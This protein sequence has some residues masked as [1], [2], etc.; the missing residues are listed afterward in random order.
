MPPPLIVPQSIAKTS[1]CLYE[2]IVRSA[3]IPALE[4]ARLFCIS[5]FYDTTHCSGEADQ[6]ECDIAGMDCK[7]V[8]NEA[9][10]SVFSALPLANETSY[11]SPC[12]KGYSYCTT[13]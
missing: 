6:Q 9:N 7:H 8:R 12:A 3:G 11:R 1:I 10:E 2:I 5:C 13:T 4:S